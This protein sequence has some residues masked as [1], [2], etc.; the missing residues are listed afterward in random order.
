MKTT[1]AARRTARI[2]QGK[3]LSA[4]ATSGRIIKRGKLK[5]WTGAVPTAPIEKAVEQSRHYTR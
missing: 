5:I 2:P 3:K 1:L 4:S